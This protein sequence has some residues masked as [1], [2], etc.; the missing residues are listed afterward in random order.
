MHMTIE[1]DVDPILVEQ[2]FH[3]PLMLDALSEMC[4]VAS[5]RAFIEETLRCSQ[6]SHMTLRP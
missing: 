2:G 3:I 5:A 1:D 4:V 6:H